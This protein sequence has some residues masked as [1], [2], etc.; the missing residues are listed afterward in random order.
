[1]FEVNKFYWRL[2]CILED[3]FIDSR[4]DFEFDENGTCRII[5]FCKEKGFKDKYYLNVKPY[6]CIEDQSRTLYELK[7]N[8]IRDVCYEQSTELN[9]E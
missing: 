3:I 5:V 2:R 4:L 6:H 9:E 7:S 1:M 8:L